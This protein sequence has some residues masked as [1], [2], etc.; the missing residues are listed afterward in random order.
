MPGPAST[1][2]SA[3]VKGAVEAVK[4]AVVS[5]M[6]AIRL[7]IFAVVV[8]AAATAAASSKVSTVTEYKTVLEGLA[9]TGWFR[10]ITSRVER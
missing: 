5:S 4:V 3:K 9:A 8:P 6:A 2:S 1:C 7:V 10:Y